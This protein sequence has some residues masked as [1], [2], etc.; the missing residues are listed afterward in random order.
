MVSRKTLTYEFYWSND[1]H[2]TCIATAVG[3]GVMACKNCGVGVHRGGGFHALWT[4]LDCGWDKTLGCGGFGIHWYTVVVCW[5]WGGCNTG[6]A[7]PLRFVDATESTNF[8]SVTSLA[9]V[10]FCSVARRIWSIDML[11]S[12]SENMALDWTWTSFSAWKAAFNLIIAWPMSEQHK[13]N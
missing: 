11:V 3:G 9:S 1:Q 8:F 12:I 5:F 4:G 6:D 7:S 13:Q 2:R 10:D